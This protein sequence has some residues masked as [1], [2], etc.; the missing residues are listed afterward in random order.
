MSRIKEIQNLVLRGEKMSFSKDETC[1]YC[2]GLL[3]EK[4]V[5]LH[6]KSKGNYVLIEGVPPRVCIQCGSR[7]YTANV[8]KTIKES[9][10]GRR[11]TEREVLVPVYSL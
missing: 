2:G 10:R 6:R 4:R 8:L 5:T 1:E 7:Y 9:I 3:V 11:K